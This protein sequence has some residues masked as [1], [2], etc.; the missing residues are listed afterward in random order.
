MSRRAER[1][2]KFKWLNQFVQSG[3][4]AVDLIS[5]GDSVALDGGARW[6]GRVLSGKGRRC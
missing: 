5:V 3:Q 4:I 1:R 2:T 6:H